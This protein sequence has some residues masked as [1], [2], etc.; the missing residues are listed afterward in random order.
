[1]KIRIEYTF[2]HEKAAAGE[3]CIASTV[4]AGEKLSAVGEDW[5]E[6]R[7]T[8]IDYVRI[9]EAKPADEEEVD[10]EPEPEEPEEPED[11]PEPEKRKPTRKVKSGRSKSR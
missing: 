4:L 8:L 7:E 1:M 3:P 9:Y 6:A 2:D 5:H 11:D 10:V